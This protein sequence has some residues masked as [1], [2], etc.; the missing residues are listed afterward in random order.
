MGRQ[1]PRQARAPLGHRPRPRVLQ[2]R[3]AARGSCPN[4]SAGVL[5]E[6][7]VLCE[8]AGTRRSREEGL[9]RVRRLMT[10]AGVG[11]VLASATVLSYGASPAVSRAA[12]ASRTGFVSPHPTF[13]KAAAFD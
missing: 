4:D 3:P 8:C 6:A 9:M 1:R 12:T 5:A 11:A 10:F 2:A 13:T 7:G